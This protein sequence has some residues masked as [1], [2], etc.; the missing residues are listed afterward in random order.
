[1][2]LDETAFAWFYGM[3]DVFNRL[4]DRKLDFFFEQSMGERTAGLEVRKLMWRCYNH[5]EASPPRIGCNLIQSLSAILSFSLDRLFVRRAQL[6]GFR[7]IYFCHFKT[8]WGIS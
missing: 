5:N 1:M 7:V 2:T 6:D 8:K 4:R 3:L